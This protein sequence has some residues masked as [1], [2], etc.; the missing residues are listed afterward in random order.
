[1]LGLEL[2]APLGA[3]ALVD[4]PVFPLVLGSEEHGY[5]SRMVPAEQ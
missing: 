5:A 4:A 3:R 2:L 1:L